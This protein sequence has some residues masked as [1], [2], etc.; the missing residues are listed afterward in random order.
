MSNKNDRA[1]IIYNLCCWLVVLPSASPVDGR[2]ARRETERWARCDTCGGVYRTM[3]PG[4]VPWAR[5]IHGLCLAHDPDADFSSGV[6]IV[7]GM[8]GACE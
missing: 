2:L 4:D 3:V 6:S 8:G 5:P 7:K 1:E